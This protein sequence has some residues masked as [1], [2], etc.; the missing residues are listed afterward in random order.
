MSNSGELFF[1][2]YLAHMYLPA[3]LGKVD[4]FTFG[5]TVGKMKSNFQHTVP[6]AIITIYR[7]TRGKA[8]L[9]IIW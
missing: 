5:Q 8:G 3:T 4:L 1:H 7:R 2:C 6:L 9:Y